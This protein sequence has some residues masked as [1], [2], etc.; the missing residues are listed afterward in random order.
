M[1][2]PKDDFPDDF[3]SG[4]LAY[5]AGRDQSDCPYRHDKEEIP[6][7]RPGQR[8]AWLAGWLEAAYFTDYWRRKLER[9]K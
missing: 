7:Y 3:E 8:R 1:N 6:D 9:E 2:G 5:L 4:R